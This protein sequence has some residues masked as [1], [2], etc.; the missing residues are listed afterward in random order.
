[1]LLIICLLTACK[2]D[3]SY[4]NSH[5]N[6]DFSDTSEEIKNNTNELPTEIENIR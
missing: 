6:S 2:T 3:K 5:L 1:M 4:N